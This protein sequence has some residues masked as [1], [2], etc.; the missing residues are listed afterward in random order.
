MVGRLHSLR[1]SRVLA[2]LFLAA[3]LSLA[4]RHPDIRIQGEKAFNARRVESL[5]GVPDQTQDWQAD[6]WQ[7]WAEDAASLLAEAYHDEGYF[8][9]LA[10]VDAPSLDSAAGK[11]GFVIQVRVSEGPRYRFGAVDIHLPAG[12]FPNYPPA[13]LRCRTGKPFDKSFIYSDHRDLLKFYGDAGFLKAQAA[14]SLFY[15]TSDKLVN[16]A[17][18]VDPRQALVFDTLT[19]RIQREGDTT[20]LEGRTSAKL[21]RSLFTLHRGDTLSLKDINAFE[22]KLKSTRAYSFVRIRDSLLPDAG[23]RSALILNAEEKIPGELEGS[24]F[25]ENLYGLGGSLDWSQA[26]MGG[27][28][29]EGHATLSLAQRKQSTFLGYGAPL[30]FGTSVRFDNDFLVDWYQDAALVQDRGWFHGNFDVSNES[31]L[32]KQFLPWLRVVSGTE[33]L[34]NSTVSDSGRQREFNLNYINSVF[35]EQIDDPVNPTQGVK[36]ALTWGNG[37]PVF[38]HGNFS[39]FEN[40]ANWLEANDAAYIPFGRWLVT[41]LRLDGGRFFGHGGINSE[42]FYLGGPRSVRSQD[43]HHL[44]P[45]YVNGICNDDIEPAYFLASGEL[46]FQPFQPSW[47]SPDGKWQHLLGLQIVPFVDYGNIWEVGHSLT[48]TGEGRA[49]GLGLRYV[50]LSLFNIR[51]DYAFDPRDNPR[52]ISEQRVILDLSQAF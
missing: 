12:R 21:L 25:W 11:K 7:S 42:R 15:D 47:I 40:R 49:V 22:R 37:A 28:L 3:A 26:N 8:D 13:D 1:V 30:L 23:G 51:I 34:G 27:H 6:D 43:W 52:N 32:S 35:L 9:A 19:L 29:Q 20:G 10:E 41:A 14:E 5:L 46:R 45:E 18:H 38:E 2:G 24:A 31:K 4:A 17:F 50:F 48:A 44:C 39:I 16:V 33:L 36:V